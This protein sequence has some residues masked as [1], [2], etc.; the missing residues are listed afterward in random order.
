MPKLSES[1]R[2]RM[3]EELELLDELEIRQKEDPLKYS[4]R[5]FKQS[6]FYKAPQS[7]RALFWGNRVGK[8]EVG[9]M[10]VARYMLGEHEYRDIKTPVEVWSICPSFDAQAETTQKKL[11]KYIP[12]K[13][14]DD[15]A[16][17]RKGIYS[18]IKLKNGSVVNF[19]SYEQGRSKFQGAGKRLIWFDEEPPHDIYEEC[20]VRQEAGQP[21]DIILT[22]TPIKGMTWVYDD[23]YLS[24]DTD[25][26]YISTAGWDDNPF[27]TEEQKDIMS[28]GLTP[29]AIEVRR[30]GRF[31]KRV[32]LVCNWWDR[33]V[34]LRDY[35]ELPNYF[36]Y[37]EVLDG[38]YSDP[39]AWLLIG[40]DGDD[41]V[42]VVDGFREAYLKTSDI[43]SKRDI[44]IAGI[45]LR[46]GFS[47][48]DNPRMLHELSAQGMNLRPVNKTVTNKASWDEALAEKLA[49][50]GQIQ[51]GTGKPRLYISNSLMRFD[52][53]SGREQNWLMQEIESLLWL[54]K[55][56]SGVSEQKPTWDDHRRFG[57][58]FD[59]IR[60]LAY[61]LWMYKKADLTPPTA[62]VTP[63][64]DDPYQRAS[65]TVTPDF[66]RGIL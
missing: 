27:L 49:E 53:K 4:E 31:T 45:P 40:V 56:T 10:E 42:H 1:Q 50:Y 36:T 38:G 59:G 3:I 44:K 25:L 11:L 9:A 7:T 2:Q 21:L 37:F 57:H 41:N 63:V 34:H 61:F 8:T 18:Y 60:A 13:E 26:Y 58:H 24:T 52:E 5:H 16:T 14:I 15:T 30:Y 17:I 47:D 23:I 64:R 65:H 54:E 29:E 20:I 28:R 66:E 22:M 32:G 55:V 46:G 51:A 19:K 48:T 39:T 6:A 35:P 62:V 12:E 43:K 33:M